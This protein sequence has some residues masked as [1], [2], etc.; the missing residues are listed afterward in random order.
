MAKR[1]GFTLA[2]V[3]TVVSF[4][5]LS[6][7]QATS[8]SSVK[9][10]LAGVVADSSGAVI[11][12]ARVTLSGPTGDRT[13]TTDAQGRFI[14]PVLTPGVYSVKVG[15]EGFKTAEVKSAEVVTG[16]TSEV[17][18]VMEVGA[19]GEVVE[20]KKGTATT[21]HTI[22]IKPGARLNALE[23]VAVLLYHPPQTGTPNQ[24]LPN[25]EKKK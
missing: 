4:S 19:A 21:P 5:I 23:E 9:G 10:N 14:F 8:A 11:Q 1:F 15:K 2:L 16:R 13:A 17:T 18:L 25:V 20:V 7:S 24:V 12:G 6:F 3:L 22:Y